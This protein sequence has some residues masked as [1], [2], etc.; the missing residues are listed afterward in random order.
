MKLLLNRI[1][2]KSIYT[3]SRLYCDIDSYPSSRLHINE[4]KDIKG[5]VY[6]CDVLE[7]T[8]RGLKQGMKLSEIQRIKQPKYTA[9][10]TGTYTVTLKIQSPKFSAYSY[11]MSY[12]KA[13]LPRLLN[14]DGYEGILIHGCFFVPLYQKFIIILYSVYL[15][16]WNQ[17]RT[18]DNP[19]F[20][21]GCKFQYLLFIIEINKI[22]FNRR[23]INKGYGC[24]TKIIFIV[25]YF[26]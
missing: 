9:I 2:R 21:I 8:S 19:L 7:D 11:Y 16:I 5:Y 3:I 14:V 6:L 17:Y 25:Y 12:C 1:A 20:I 18:Y 24:Q 10:P 23:N 22:L 26:I 4:S 15:L 13:Y